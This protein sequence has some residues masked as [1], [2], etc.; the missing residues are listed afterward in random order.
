MFT[1]AAAAAVAAFAA[2][3]SSRVSTPP[4]AVDDMS[5]DS[6]AI[7]I[8]ENSQKQRTRAVVIGSIHDPEEQTGKLHMRSF[9][10]THDDDSLEFCYNYTQHTI[11]DRRY[12]KH[13]EPRMTHVIQ[14]LD[15]GLNEDDR[16]WY[17]WNAEYV[18]GNSPPVF[19]YIVYGVFD[20]GDQE[21]ASMCLFENYKDAKKYLN[22][23]MDF[24]IHEYG[25][26]EALNA[27]GT[28]GQRL[29]FIQTEY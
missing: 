11:C 14:F 15:N 12:W 16:Y 10:L 7:D 3:S 2:V 5:E 18:P 13:D 20:Y 22:H 23:M 1:T 8:P 28:I 25:V 19:N 4:S 24:G 21:K 9:R 6:H 17:S 26:I 27:N 29:G